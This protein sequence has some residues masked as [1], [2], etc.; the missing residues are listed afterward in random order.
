MIS[1]ATGKWITSP[2]DVARDAIEE[3]TVERSKLRDALELGEVDFTSL[4]SGELTLSPRLAKRLA[5]ALGGTPRFW[6][7][8]EG[9]YR[10]ERT[11]DAKSLFCT[12][13]KV[14]RIRQVY[15]S[16]GCY[17]YS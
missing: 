5:S 14:N 4:L 3:G 7:N 2:G 15:K 8:L 6:E 13:V 9:Q 1:M 11:E 17:A 12:P 10:K 16:I